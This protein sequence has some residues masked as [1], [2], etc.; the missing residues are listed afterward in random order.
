MPD[1]SQDEVKDAMMDVTHA[2]N[3]ILDAL[4]TSVDGPYRQLLTVMK[5]EK[6]PKD[7]VHG[8]IHIIWRY[9]A[10]FASSV[11]GDVSLKEYMD[12]IRILSK[13]SEPLDD[14]EF[15]A[16]QWMFSKSAELVEKRGSSATLLFQS[17]LLD[18]LKTL[19]KGCL[20]D[21][22][23]Y[24]ISPYL[25]TIRKK[26]KDLSPDEDEKSSHNDNGDEEIGNPRQ[27]VQRD[28]HSEDLHEGSQEAPQDD[29]QSSTSGTGSDIQQEH[30]ETEGQ[31]TGTPH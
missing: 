7:V 21:L 26:L 15:V 12:S 3:N 8:L 1:G 16:A 24:I 6:I 14:D 11:S 9:D 10:A 27:D 23:A 30:A 4:P 18:A 17:G 25:L 13:T 19:R 22:A 20:D 28:N 31:S 2:L 29:H 5:N